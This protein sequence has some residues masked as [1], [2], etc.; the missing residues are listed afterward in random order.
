MNMA[1]YSPA[2]SLPAGRLPLSFLIATILPFFAHSG[3]SMTSLLE[4][5]GRRALS[6]PRTLGAFAATTAN[7]KIPNREIPLSCGHDVL[8]DLCAKGFSG[9]TRLIQLVE[10]CFET[11][12]T[13]I[14][15]PNHSG[16]KDVTI[17]GRVLMS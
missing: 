13:R 6:P 1:A 15:L 2:N 9:A 11:S 10:Q 8:F 17:S 3:Q 12:H 14:I 5:E 16:R 4:A 7:R